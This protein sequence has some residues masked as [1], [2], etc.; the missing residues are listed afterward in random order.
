MM[1]IIGTVALFYVIIEAAGV[2]AAV[3]LFLLAYSIIK[4]IEKREDKH[5]KD[6]NSRD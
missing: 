6:R 3:M 5:D 2:V 1:E 4:A